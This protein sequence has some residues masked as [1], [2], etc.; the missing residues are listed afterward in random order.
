[1]SK[2][3]VL[4]VLLATAI[5]M[6]AYL[7][8]TMWI[9]PSAGSAWAP[10]PTLVVEDS[11]A[12]RPAA[13]SRITPSANITIVPAPMNPEG[14]PTRLGTLTLTDSITGPAALAE[15]AQLH[16]KGFDLT[17]GFMAHYAGAGTQATLWVG[18]AKDA[19]AA[20]VMVDTMTQKIGAGNAIFKDLQSLQIGPRTMFSVN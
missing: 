18:Q 4:A 17:N 1:M 16:G 20:A 14:I 12:S 13:A 2:R 10:R 19:A 6:G 9:N 5:F 15:I 3:Y 11:F 7:V 8:W